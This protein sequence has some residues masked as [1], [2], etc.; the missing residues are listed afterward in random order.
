MNA[1]QF[2][3]ITLLLLLSVAAAY[4]RLNLDGPA[5]TIDLAQPGMPLPE[6]M[7]DR[8]LH[9]RVQRSLSREAGASKVT[10]EVHNAVAILGG[11]V[12]RKADKDRAAQLALDAAGIA[13][14]HNRIYVEDAAAAGG[15]TRAGAIDS[16]S[17]RDL[18]A[19]RS[20]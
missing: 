4:V 12:E 16:T 7:I 10:I 13:S 8:R 19:V 20:P 17:A 14:V 15:R 18:S 11:V 3:A 6:T 9:E 2:R 5:G 1:S